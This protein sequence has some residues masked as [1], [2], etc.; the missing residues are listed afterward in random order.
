MPSPMKSAE[1]DF[2]SWAVK[3]FQQKQQHSALPSAEHW[4]WV[5]GALVEPFSSWV[6]QLVWGVP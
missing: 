5:A 6:L 3:S 4:P 2:V 1:P